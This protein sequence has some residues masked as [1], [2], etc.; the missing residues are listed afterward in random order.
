VHL[1]LCIFGTQHLL[2]PLITV[3][4]IEDLNDPTI[5]FHYSD[6]LSSDL[7]DDILDLLRLQLLVHLEE[8]HALEGLALRDHRLTYLQT[9]NALLERPH[10]LLVR[11][12]ELLGVVVTKNE[13]QGLR[14]DNS[15]RW[16]VLF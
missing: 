13:V 2:G 1:E 7:R 4:N 15:E 8:V 16:D 10:A 12:F 11:K 5:F 3:I 9:R 14:D 6:I